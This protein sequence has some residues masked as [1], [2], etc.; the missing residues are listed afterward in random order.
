MAPGPRNKFGAPI[1]EP[2]VVCTALKKAL[3]TLLELFGAPVVIRHPGNCTP[4]HRRYDPG[5][6]N[7]TRNI[8]YILFP[9]KGIT[10]Y[11]QII[12]TSLRSFKRDLFTRWPIA[13]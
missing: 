10:S 9:K 13:L 5:Y 4:C 1:F 7:L 2:E 8:F 6:L 11:R 3:V 12:Y